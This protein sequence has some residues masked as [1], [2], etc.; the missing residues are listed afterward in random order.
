MIN[1]IIYPSAAEFWLNPNLKYDYPDLY[2]RKWKY[3]SIPKHYKSMTNPKAARYIAEELQLSYPVHILS[4]EMKKR[5]VKAQFVCRCRQLQFPPKSF[6]K[7]SEE[8]ID[9]ENVNFFI[10]TPELCFLEAAHQLSLIELIRFG[11]DL[12]SM[13]VPDENAEFGQ[14]SRKPI[15]TPKLLSEYLSKADGFYGV[16]KARRA[17]KYVL[18]NSNSPMETKLAMIM[19]LPFSMGGFGL[20]KPKLNHSIKL[21]AAG[22]KLLGYEAIKCDIAWPDRKR[23]IEYNS[24]MCHLTPQQITEDSNR[25][26]ALSRLG[27]KVISLTAGNVNFVSNIESIM[28]SVRRLLGLRKETEKLKKYAEERRQ[29]EKWLFYD[30]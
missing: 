14:S 3:V 15:T 27:Y 7:I 11:F 25:Q 10:A 29:L 22:R 4:Q 21:D 13:Y 2:D 16:K 5:C 12:C 28:A 8:V 17:V 30:S 9:K 19:E 6:I 18:E 20:P 26:T 24:N 23:A 1:P